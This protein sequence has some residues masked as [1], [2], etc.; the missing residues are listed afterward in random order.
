MPTISIFDA[1][2]HFSRIIAQVASLEE[3]EFVVTKNGTP[4][5][6]IVPIRQNDAVR[7][8]GIARGAFDVPGDIDGSNQEIVSLFED[9]G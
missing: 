4:V 5:A 7:R 8:V 3:H 1:K 6:R 9:R 2:T